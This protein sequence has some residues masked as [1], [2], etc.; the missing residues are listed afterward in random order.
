MNGIPVTCRD[1]DSF[2]IQS[3]MHNTCVSGCEVRAQKDTLLHR[4]ILVIVIMRY[5]RN[6]TENLR[7]NTL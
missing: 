4:E 5:A 2:I 7:G 6:V 3:S 1:G